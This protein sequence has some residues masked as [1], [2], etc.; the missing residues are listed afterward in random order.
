MPRGFLQVLQS[1]L[2]E[3]HG[4]LVPALGGVLDHQVV[5]GSQASWDLVAAL[6]G[7][8][9]RCAVVLVLHCWVKGGQRST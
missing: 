9:H 1:L 3:R 5:Q 8:S 6:L 4:D 7:C 2:A